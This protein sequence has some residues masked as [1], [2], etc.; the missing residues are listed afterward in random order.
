MKVKIFS[1]MSRPKLTFSGKL[2]APIFNE[3][4]QAVND[5]FGENPDIKIYKI[6]HAVSSGSFLSGAEKLIITVFYEG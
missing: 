5:W 6:E 4:E 1:D 2:K 3:L